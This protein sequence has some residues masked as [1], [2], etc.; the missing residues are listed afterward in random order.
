M[1]AAGPAFEQVFAAADATVSSIPAPD[2]HAG[3]QTSVLD[4]A[5]MSTLSIRSLRLH[6]LAKCLT[7]PG[8]HAL[9]FSYTPVLMSK[10]AFDRLDER[11]RSALL[12]A[13][14]RAE[15]FF[16]EQTRKVDAEL[17]DAARKAGVTVVEMNAADLGSWIDVARRSAFKKF[18]EEV[19]GGDELIA[20]ALEVN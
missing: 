10:Q 6:E 12:E 17:V 16:H 15:A 20:R 4:G 3:M 7:A 19:K 11:Q 8:E 13:G 5:L 9:W 14:K 18:A 2:I 1:R